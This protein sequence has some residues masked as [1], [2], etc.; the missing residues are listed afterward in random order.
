MKE[1][2][3]LIRTEG[4]YSAGMTPEACQQHARKAG[5]YIYWQTAERGEA[6]RRRAAEYGG[7]HAPGTSER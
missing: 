1:F 4:D 3:L 6:Q 7:Q 2:M 5:T